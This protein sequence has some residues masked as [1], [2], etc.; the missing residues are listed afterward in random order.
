MFRVHQ[1]AKS[2][3]RKQIQPVSVAYMLSVKSPLIAKTAF[4]KFRGMPGVSHPKDFVGVAHSPYPEHAITSDINTPDHHPLM[5]NPETGE[6]I[7]LSALNPKP[8]HGEAEGISRHPMEWVMNDLDKN[9]GDNAGKTIL[10][11]AIALYNQKHDDYGDGSNHKMPEDPEDPLYNKVFLGPH[12]KDDV[13]THMRMIRGV[14]ELPETGQRPV[15]TYSTNK[16]NVDHPAAMTGDIVDGGFVHC[17]KEIGEVLAKYNVDPKLIN[18]LPYVRRNTLKAHEMTNGLVDS[19]NKHQLDAAY[20][21]NQ[22]PSHMMHPEHKA[23]LDSQRQHPEI[24]IHQ[25]PSLLPK[26]WYYPAM[27]KDGKA[28]A[29]GKNDIGRLK[30]LLGNAGIDSGEISD[31]YLNLLATTR[32]FRLM[33]G[34]TQPFKHYSRTYEEGEGP[35]GKHAAA[36][37]LG[38]A[39]L[40]ELGANPD[41]EDMEIYASQAKAGMINH[42]LDIN[43]HANHRAAELVSN[44]YFV[45]GEKMKNGMSQEEATLDTMNH[46]EEMDLDHVGRQDAYRPHPE[47]NFGDTAKEVLEMMLG[48][49]GHETFQFGDVPTEA[50]TSGI[51][52]SMREGNAHSA[53]ED[54]HYRR[55]INRSD[56]APQANTVRTEPIG[57]PQAEAPPLAS[58]AEPLAPPS[59]VAVRG[60]PASPIFR[61][62]I[63][64][65]ADVAARGQS[66]FDPALMQQ[67]GTRQTMFDPFARDLSLVDPYAPVRTSNDVLTGLDDILRKMEQ[68]QALD[69]MQDDSVRKLLP[70]DKVSISS[71]WDVQRVAKSLG[72]TSVDVHG[73]YQSTGDWH[74]VADQWNVK[75]DVVKAVKI[76]FGGV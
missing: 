12:Y 65:E 62:P 69:A 58:V 1:P 66:Q 48:H 51:P 57:E 75:P 63:Q 36:T 11:E 30:S 20:R 21:H 40:R 23:A 55:M 18:S 16:S 45:I 53:F 41:H 22:I 3:F 13:Q 74:K 2:Y 42:D 59:R 9:F 15:A 4:Q 56:L 54:H 50:I 10:R 61:R 33:L 25:V 24:Q 31:D 8:K 47:E 27:T 67:L 73:L 52:Q 49:T 72:I 26:A 5:H 70:S 68:V 17:N 44:I 64:A 14:E 39:M 28:K 71:F 76:A 19:Y 38:G 43:Q 7:G 29:V 32:A 37:K 6:L 34:Y 46:L 35:K 60:A